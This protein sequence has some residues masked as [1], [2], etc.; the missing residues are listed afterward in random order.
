MQSDDL[1]YAQLSPR[2]AKL[3]AN[4]GLGES[5][6]FLTWFLENIYRLE[7]TE[8]RD[9]ICDDAQDKGIDGIYV[10][11]NSEQVHFLQAKLRQKDSGTVGDVQPKNLVASMK[12]LDA[13]DK[14]QAFL[15]GNSNDEIKKIIQRVRLVELVR[16]GYELIAVFV[17][18][19]QHDENSRN[20]RDIT[21]ELR[22][23]DRDEIAS[24]FIE[25]DAPEAGKDSFT[26]DVS[27]V[28]PLEMI[29]GSGYGRPKMYMF[30][31]RAIQ[32][33]HMEGIADGTLFRGNVRYALGSTPVNRSIKR[34]IA[35]KSEHPD[36]VLFHNGIIVLCSSVTTDAPGQLTLHD[37]SVVN[38][39]QS[40]TSFY[41][42][43]SKLTDD[44]MV[45]VRVIVV[46]DETLAAKITENSNNQ[47]AIKP[48]DLRSNHIL[49]LRLQ[50]EM[51]ESEP[52]YFFEIKRGEKAPS[53]VTVISNEIAGR[54]LLAFDLND[55]WSAHQIYKV[56]DDKYADI[57][58]RPEV[59]ARRIVLL[60]RLLGAVETEIVALDDR[61]M[62]SYTLTRYFL[63]FLLARIARAAAES[64]PF[65]ANP[66]TL[67][68]DGL[69]KFVT[70]CH[71]I[72]KTLV[73]DL[74]YEARAEGFDYKLVFKSP[75]QGAELADRMLK[76]YEKDVAQG[77][78]DSFEGWIQ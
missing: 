29:A 21:P 61:P 2:I 64:K 68:A 25:V 60:S 13:E 5:A 54:A 7:S 6:A 69:E 46:Q 3:Q 70:S 26:V 75:I 14:I 77:K 39:A 36:F 20:Y 71:Q 42:E 48:R 44:L 59:T 58:G 55:P 78:A 72:L 9:A 50:K 15:A 35:Q 66:S 12:Q 51:S 52:N 24:R 4:T 18:N 37:Y 56:F 34:S 43:K 63:L 67:T 49:M 47:N 23:Y 1:K 76:S 32:L 41:D 53:G 10:D 30:P 33:V 11:H 65:V 31:A 28:E 74:N 40:L 16:E 38:G 27:Y 19:G 17:S 22:I 57:F 8:A 62:A 73:I 45:L